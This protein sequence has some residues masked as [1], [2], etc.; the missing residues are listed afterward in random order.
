M[1][2]IITTKV[3]PNKL[4]SQCYARQKGLAAIEFT[5]ILPFLLL[6]IFSCSE[7]GRLL[8]QYNTL[9]KNVRSATRYLS[10]HVK[11]GDNGALSIKSEVAAEAKDLVR[12]GQS[13]GSVALLPNLNNDDINLVIDSEFVVITVTY[14]WQPIFSQTLPTFGFG[15]DISLNFPLVSTYSM[16]VL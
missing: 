13:G 14:L 11:Y 12:F 6:L 16:R 3:R 10:S 7:F 2:Q 4:N 8:Y 15:N 1:Q 5:I 9:N